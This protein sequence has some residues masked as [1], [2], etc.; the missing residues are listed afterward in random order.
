MARSRR[1]GQRKEQILKAAERVFARKGFQEST[2]SDVAR[3]AGVSEATIYEYF[4]SK[5]ELLFSIPGETTRKGKE[6]LEFHLQ[7]VRGA[8]NKIRSIIYHY[9]SFYQNNTDYAAI[10]M[11]VLKQNRKFVETEPYQMVREG[12]RVILRVV[13]EGIASG[14][15]SPSVNPFLVRSVILGTIENILIRKLLHGKPEDLVAFV[16]PLTDMVIRGIAREAVSGCWNLRLILEPSTPEDQD[17]EKKKAPT[18]ACKRR[19]KR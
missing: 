13:E 9:L 16:D 15:F 8:A 5:E 6:I 12:S 1:L 18:G 10:A 17:T 3:E 11:L 7:Y 19:R 4:P 14:E 2:V